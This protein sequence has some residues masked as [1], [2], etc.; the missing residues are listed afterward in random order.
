MKAP[1][2]ENVA[3]IRRNLFQNSQSSVLRARDTKHITDHVFL[4]VLRCHLKTAMVL[5]TQAAIHVLYNLSGK[6]FKK[7]RVPL[8]PREP[9][10]CVYRYVVRFVL[11]Y[12]CGVWGFGRDGLCG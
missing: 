9:R 7:V 11:Q 6:M 2:Q 12:A 3:E 5:L 10:M 1:S 8:I 4:L